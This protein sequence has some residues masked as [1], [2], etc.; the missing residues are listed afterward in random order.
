MQIKFKFILFLFILVPFLLSGQGAPTKI[1][2]QQ[3]IMTYSEVAMRKMKE[4]RIPASISL[5]QGILESSNGNSDLALYANNHFGIKCHKEWNGE[6]YLKDDDAKDECFRKYRSAEESFEDHSTFLCTR[7]RYSFLFDL[8]VTDYKAWAHGLKKAGYATNPQYPEKLIKI[9]EENRLFEYDQQTILPVGSPAAFPIDSMPVRYKEKAGK[10]DFGEI[11]LSGSSRKVSK[12]N[13]V[14]YTLA[15]KNDNIDRLA[16]DLD[17]MPWQ[18]MRYNELDSRESF[19]EGQ[20]VYLQPKRRKAEKEYHIVRANETMYSIAQLH[21]I[22]LKQLYKMN[23]MQSG[24][25]AVAGQK[26]WLRKSKP[27]R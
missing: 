8:E 16:R 23:R 7:S 11:T 10:G 18:I 25:Q 21:G 27:A 14:K 1:T 20:V 4:H 24:E 19:T 5:A 6:T 9:I 17:I 12:N 2:V 22:K 15:K 13:N 26:L 3:Y